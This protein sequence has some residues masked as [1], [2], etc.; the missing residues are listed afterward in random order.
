MAEAQMRNAL[1]IGEGHWTVFVDRPLSAG[2]FAVC[3]VVLFLPPLLKRIK[4][5]RSAAEPHTAHG[6]V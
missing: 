2:I 1:S 3:A 5:F 4:L 6:P